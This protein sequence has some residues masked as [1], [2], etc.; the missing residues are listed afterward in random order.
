MVVNEQHGL[1]LC[2]LGGKDLS[3]T[4]LFHRQS[5]IVHFGKICFYYSISRECLTVRN[6]GQEA[7]WQPTSVP[8]VP[9]YSAAQYLHISIYAPA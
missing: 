5:A 3:L 2:V 9:T 1:A 6:F 7:A 8:A 4:V